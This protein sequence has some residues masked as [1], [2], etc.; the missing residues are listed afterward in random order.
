MPAP[1]SYTTT[2]GVQPFVTRTG[3]PYNG[4]RGVRSFQ[5]QLNVS[6]TMWIAGNYD[7]RRLISSFAFSYNIIIDGAVE[8]NNELCLHYRK[9]PYKSSGPKR[10]YLRSTIWTLTA[11]SIKSRCSLWKSS[12]F[13][14][15]DVIIVSV[16][17][18]DV[19]TGVESTSPLT[20][21]GLISN[22]LPLFGSEITKARGKIAFTGTWYL[23]RV[24]A[25]NFALI[26]DSNDLCVD[27]LPQDDDTKSSCST[28]T[29]FFKQ[30]LPKVLPQPA[31]QSSDGELKLLLFENRAESETR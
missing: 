8:I 14:R 19:Q 28:I 6:G 9:W 10:L 23:G 31:I 29:R 17:G 21:S 3:A 11:V 22:Q 30:T 20:Q 7:R 1:K 13:A 24:L 2:I 25:T 26:V 27:L 15:I 5:D 16:D 4:A 12:C 18:L